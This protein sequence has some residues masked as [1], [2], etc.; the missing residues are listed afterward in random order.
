M[1]SEPTDF[2]ET[3]QAV[4]I[5]K[6]TPPPE[7]L[8]DSVTMALVST[9]PPLGQVT[10][11]R[12][13]EVGITAVLEVQ[14]S[15]ASSPWEV[16]LWHSHP[17]G[18]A[19]WIEHR[20]SLS[21]PD[22]IPSDLQATSD[23][24]RL[25]FDG[26][27]TLKSSMTFTVKFRA[28]PD[29]DWRWIRDEADMDEGTII[30]NDNTD[31]KDTETGIPDLIAGFNPELKWQPH[32]SQCPGTRLW[33][34]EAPVDAAHGEESA[35]A[36]VPLGTPWGG[37][38]R[39]FAVVRLWAPWLAPRHGKDWFALD[40]D[41]IMCSFLSPQGRHMVVLA[42]SGLTDVMTVLRSGSS[43][44]VVLHVCKTASFGPLDNSC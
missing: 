23:V 44:E 43:G 13:S 27:V 42:I 6:Q 7:P 20:L 30:L 12:T 15:D 2:A 32:M 8:P 1:T 22:A 16:A 10:Q 39:W 18:E 25:Y 40:K 34:V 21:N 9:Y 36:D 3:F 4:F 33:S 24:S 38:T 37:F 29:Q 28:G 31:Q 26:K 35:F 17:A 11:L 41:A 14:E 5:P 19:Q